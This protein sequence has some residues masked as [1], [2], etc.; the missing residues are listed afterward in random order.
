MWYM[1][2][3]V[4]TAGCP[5]TASRSR[6][7]RP[8]S[9]PILAP[10]SSATLNTSASAGHL[11]QPACSLHLVNVKRPSSALRHSKSTHFDAMNL[12]NDK[13]PSSARAAAQAQQGLEHSLL[14]GQ[15]T[16]VLR[17]AG[18]SNSAGRVS[19]VPLVIQP[20]MPRMA[21][22]DQ[23]AVRLAAGL[24]I[25]I[26]YCQANDWHSFSAGS[27]V[28]EG[29]VN[30]SASPSASPP[31]S[32]SVAQ[33]S[34]RPPP[35]ARRS[36]LLVSCRHCSGSPERHRPVRWQPDVDID[37][38]SEAG[39]T[40]IPLRLA[41]ET[42]HGFGDRLPHPSP[43]LQSPPQ[44]VRPVQPRAPQNSPLQHSPLKNSPLQHSPLQ[45][46]PLQSSRAPPRT[47]AAVDAQGWDAQQ[48]A[49]FVGSLGAPLCHHAA[50]FL[51]N[52]VTGARLG[53][54]RADELPQLGVRR[55]EEILS[56]LGHIRARLE[57]P[58]PPP[59]MRC[60]T[61]SALHQP[62][63]PPPPPPPPPSLPPRKAR[64]N[65]QRYRELHYQLEREAAQGP[66]RRSPPKVSLHQLDTIQPL[67]QQGGG[68]LGSQTVACL[69][70][71]LAP[72]VAECSGSH[73]IVF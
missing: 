25:D 18:R 29:S 41:S 8:A 15:K 40:P 56:L 4:S 72:E 16:L 1:R 3:D 70:Q 43:P 5:S 21:P 71:R 6:V 63:L 20:S 68:A 19:R 27:S 34:R 35:K 55:F 37:E 28:C 42:S 54:V 31:A 22:Q 23:P 44:W 65:E 53:V 73:E 59:T 7:G 13:R 24:R 51:A 32:P 14:F 52:G 60:A 57:L 36:P 33:T 46:S 26:R 12:L 58:P 66:I 62:P 47:P 69:L 11:C 50:A 61:A 45:H 39:P 17:S 2:E 9:A 10:R 64:F 67:L 38:V 48:V 30:L 49:A